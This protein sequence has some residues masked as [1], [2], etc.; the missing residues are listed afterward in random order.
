MVYLPTH[1]H[2]IRETIGDALRAGLRFG[3][4]VVVFLLFMNTVAPRYI[5]HGQSMEPSIHHDER[6]LISPIPYLLDQPQRGDVIVFM[7]QPDDA[8]VKRVIG[9]P[10]ETVYLHRGRVYVNGQLIDEP[11]ISTP[12][13]VCADH[14][15]KLGADEFFVLGDNRNISVDSHIFG[16]IRRDQIVGQVVL[17]WWPQ[18]QVMG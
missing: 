10:G 5:V 8:L 18:L 12:C 6:L 14:V 7:R 13:F 9:L 1:Q 15:W 3:L 17:R 11:Y 2:S 4:T 16:P